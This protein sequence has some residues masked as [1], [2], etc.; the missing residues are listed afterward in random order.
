MKDMCRNGIKEENLRNVPSLETQELA[1]RFVGAPGDFAPWVTAEENCLEKGYAPRNYGLADFSVVQA[2]EWFHC[3]HI[4]R[5]PESSCLWRGHE[6][7]LGHAVTKD[8]DTWFTRDPVIC[9]D[10]AH[11]YE[12]SHVWA[13]H[14]YQHD[15]IWHMFYTGLN[16]ECAQCLC[17]A[18]AKDEMLD[19][20][21]KNPDNPVIPMAGFDWQLKN[22][23]ENVRHMRD[24]HIVEYDGLYV[25][26]YTTQHK[27]GC[28]AVGAVVSEDFKVWED[29]GPI[30]FRPF[31]PA[32][33]FPGCFN[34]EHP[35][36]KSTEYGRAMW[37]PESVNL[38]P[39]PDGTW[40]LIPS[41]S[42]G[43]EVYFSDTPLS[44]HE[45]AAP[46]AIRYLDGPDE[47]PMAMEV[48]HRD[49]ENMTWLITY[50][51]E[52][53]NR[54]FTGE[55]NIEKWELKSFKKGKLQ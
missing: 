16:H 32:W 38:Q 30:F 51:E 44:F 3:F 46:V 55:L 13:P 34:E 39:M 45:S 18:V 47:E 40:C 6:A 8:F 21:E 25:M 50:F 1:D 20:W 29:I 9:S 33:K 17:H 7:W 49:D 15:G 4:P 27:D 28:P 5:V 52:H 43:M 53:N 11:D 24:P 36:A 37:H 2:G 10:P 42:P 23:N 14:V 35:L 26:A 22:R 31:N 41:Q 12:R 54:L 48:V 19:V